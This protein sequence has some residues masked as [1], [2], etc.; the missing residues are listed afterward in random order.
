[1]EMERGGGG[2][3]PATYLGTLLIYYAG[4]G[5]EREEGDIFLTL[6]PS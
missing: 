1:M 2:G 3:R 6:V 4:E 5:G